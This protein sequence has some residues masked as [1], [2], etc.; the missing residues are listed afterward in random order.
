MIGEWEKEKC[1][2]LCE[3]IHADREAWRAAQETADKAAA[4]A[5]TKKIAYEASRARLAGEELDWVRGT[6]W[7]SH[8]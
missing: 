8:I 6:K 3:A 1:I 2:A 7:L 4:A 5:T